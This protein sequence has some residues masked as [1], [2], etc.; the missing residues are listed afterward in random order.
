MKPKICWNFKQSY[1][2][3][4]DEY[5]KYWV[6]LECN[7]EFCEKYVDSI[8]ICSLKL[9]YTLGKKSYYNIGNYQVIQYIK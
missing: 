9:K 2:I 5:N 3:S 7:H 6:P 4:N 8:I 1:L